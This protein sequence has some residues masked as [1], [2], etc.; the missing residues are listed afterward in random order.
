MSRIYYAQEALYGPPIQSDYITIEL[1]NF[2]SDNT[3]SNKFELQNIPVS[4]SANT[5]E[6]GRELFKYVFLTRDGIHYKAEEGDFF[7]PSAIILCD[8]PD[9]NFPTEFYFIAKIGAQIEL[10]ECS[11]GAGV[12]WFQIPQLHKPV[13]DRAIIVKVEETLAEIKTLVETTFNKQVVAEREKKER[14]AQRQV[15]KNRPLLSDKQRNAY[16]V[17]TELCVYNA[18]NKERILTFINSLKNYDINS[19][20]HT[21]LD[22]FMS[23]L[24]KVQNDFI[25]TLDWKAG[26]EDLECALQSVIKNNYGLAVDMPTQK[27][28]EEDASIS[29]DGVFEDFDKPLRKNGLQ[30]GFI[31]SNSDDY[32]ILVHKVYDRKRVETAIN[33]MGYEYYEL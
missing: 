22:C 10:R 21:T 14:K 11:G 27:D 3:D 28:Y 15:E 8:I 1:F 20:R 23:F 6:K 30:L 4:T 32:I 18:V 2:L 31:Y 16:K 26:I 12:K 5:K 7:L 24:D 29:Y 19:S 13:A 25:T 17:L 9:Y 33:D